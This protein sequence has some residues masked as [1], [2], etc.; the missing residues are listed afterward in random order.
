MVADRNGRQH[1]MVEVVFLPPFER[2][3]H[4]PDGTPPEG[5]LLAGQRRLVR[6][7]PNEIFR[8]EKEHLDLI[9]DPADGVHEKAKPPRAASLVHRIWRGIGADE[10]CSHRIILCAAQNIA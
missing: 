2:R 8:D 4:R 6:C 3:E 5:R 1:I 10:Q 7:L 9:G